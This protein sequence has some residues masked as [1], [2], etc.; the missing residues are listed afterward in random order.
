MSDN[1]ENNNNGE[2]QRKKDNKIAMKAFSLVMQLGMN[3]A[4]CVIIGFFFGRFLDNKFGTAPWLMIVFV[5]LGAGAAIKLI[6][7][8][9]KDWK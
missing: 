5:F 6:Y 7:D 4:C 2:K 1:N 3:M 9:A 8:I